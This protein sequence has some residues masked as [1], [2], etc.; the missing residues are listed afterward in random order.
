MNRKVIKKKRVRM[1]FEKK[2]EKEEEKSVSLQLG[3]EPQVMEGLR[4]DCLGAQATALP[5]EELEE[6]P[7]CGGEHQAERELAERILEECGRLWE[8]E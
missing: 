7:V 8:R 3:T 6:A 5:L 2:E 4:V 1:E